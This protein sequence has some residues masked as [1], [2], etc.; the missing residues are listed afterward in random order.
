M[1]SSI[2]I[3]NKYSNNWFYQDQNRSYPP[4]TQTTGGTIYNETLTE[5]ATAADSLTNTMTFGTTLSEALAAADSLATAMTMINSISESQTA[6]DSLANAMTMANALTESATAADSLDT[7]AVLNVTIDEDAGA[8]DNYMAPMVYDEDLEETTGAFDDYTGDLV[9]VGGSSQHGGSGWMRNMQRLQWQ[10]EQLREAKRLADEAMEP[11][12]EVKQKKARKKK[13]RPDYSQVAA[14]AQLNV[15][16][17]TINQLAN[18]IEARIS[19]I[20]AQIA[21]AKRNKKRIQDHNNA[22][23]LLMY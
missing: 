1:S 12:P 22:I 18:A 11:E 13:K 3:T 7:T 17:D 21:M 16:Y 14:A 4:I 10:L 19:E 15:N 2:N 6:N 5:T 8:F 23:F 9:V 20:N